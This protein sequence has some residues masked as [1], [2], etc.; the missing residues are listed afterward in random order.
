MIMTA[1]DILEKT[2]ELIQDPK[3]WTQGT[4]ARDVNG[5]PVLASS[6]AAV[7]WCLMGALCRIGESNKTG[8]EERWLTRRIVYGILLKK[9]WQTISEANDFNTHDDVIQLLDEAISDA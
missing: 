5:E 3:C 1:R 4:F 6:P 8:D 2:R 7:S 9:K